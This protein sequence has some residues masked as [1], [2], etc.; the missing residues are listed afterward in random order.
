MH[1]LSIA[2][3]FATLSRQHKQFASYKKFHVEKSSDGYNLQTVQV[4]PLLSVMI[5]A[6]TD[7]DTQAHLKN[8]FQQF[9][10]SHFGI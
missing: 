4:D 6:A 1:I 8:L 10:C 9:V 2:F 3:A 7:H 5:L